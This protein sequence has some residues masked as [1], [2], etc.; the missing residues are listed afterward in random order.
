ML[1]NLRTKRNGV[2]P[3]WRPP[4]RPGLPHGRLWHRQAWTVR[5]K[6]QTG[7]SR[8]GPHGS[9]GTRAHRGTLQ[10]QGHDGRCHI[11]SAE[12]RCTAA[13]SAVALAFSSFQHKRAIAAEAAFS[14]RQDSPWQHASYVFTPLSV[15]TG[16][17]GQTC[18]GLG[19]V[20]LSW[21]VHWHRA[22]Q[23]YS[24]YHCLC[25][26]QSQ[27]CAASAHTRATSTGT[28]Y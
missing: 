27:A 25:L 26:S 14:G 3:A 7:S 2:T 24:A 18:P 12:H 10:A 23:H 9:G 19:A 4:A 21:P 15:A 20:Q 22:Q 16:V 8:W 5:S 6:W 1:T 17:P 28:S 13:L 11:G